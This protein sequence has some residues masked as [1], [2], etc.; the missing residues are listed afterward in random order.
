MPEQRKKT[1]LPNL[2][3]VIVH[4]NYLIILLRFQLS[5][6]LMALILHMASNTSARAKKRQ[7]D[8]KRPTEITK[9]KKIIYENWACAV[10]K[11]IWLE[12]WLF[13]DELYLCVTKLKWSDNNNTIKLQW[14]CKMQFDNSLMMSLRVRRA[15]FF[16][17]HEIRVKTTQIFRFLILD[18]NQD[19]IDTHCPPIWNK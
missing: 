8:R 6:Y 15:L 5:R 14:T 4:S 19:T 13:C 17:L 9:Q 18:G 12:R 2:W 7:N 16:S 3:H 11:I 10:S 1:R